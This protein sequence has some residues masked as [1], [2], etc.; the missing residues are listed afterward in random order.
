LVYVVE[1]WETIEEYA[2][3]KRGFYQVLPGGEG[4]EIRPPTNFHYQIIRT[5]NFTAIK[6]NV[7]TNS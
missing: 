2:G 5:C 6:I 1:N 3:D 7:A 4:V